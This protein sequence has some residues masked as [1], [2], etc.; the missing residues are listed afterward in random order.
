MK[1]ESIH[2]IKNILILLVATVLVYLLK[3]VLT[4]MLLALLISI[5]LYPM[6]KVLQKMHIPNLL[7]ISVTLISAIG[8]LLFIFFLFTQELG[9]LLDNQS[10]II[11]RLEEINST[12]TSKM[13][14][15]RA[16]RNLLAG[17]KREV[18]VAD[19]FG[20]VSTQFMSTLQTSA[21]IIVNLA[22][23]P[24][25]CFFFLAYP[26]FFF[27]AI[28]RLFVNLTDRE[29]ITLTKDIANI[30]KEYFYGLGRVIVILA[31]LNSIGL[32]VIGIDNALFYGVLA[33]LLTIVPYVGIFVGSLLPA[34]V[35]FI[36]KDSLMY[37]VAVIAWMSFVQ[38]LEGNFITPFI[39]GNKIKINP[40]VAIVTLLLG[41]QFWGI[42]GM[43]F[44]LPA[45][46]VFKVICSRHSSLQGLCFV[47]G[48]FPKEHNRN[49]EASLLTKIENLFSFN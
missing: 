38:F 23:I 42:A 32:A 40:F 4:P 29:S 46:A 3:T 31:I 48:D 35:A 28:V 17:F 41:A 24:I 26:H 12:I 14:E 27:K 25:Y 7:A 2:T 19:F 20:N 36:T 22:L 10:D 15:T 9:M 45:I 43:V 44:A 47:L 49:T 39:I 34:L 8:L 16:G 33:S 6:V 13:N 5:M 30:L 37:G 18:T 21:G 1:E 11:A